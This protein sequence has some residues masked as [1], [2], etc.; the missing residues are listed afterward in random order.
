M[1]IEIPTT[2]PDETTKPLTLLTLLAPNLTR[3]EIFG[4]SEYRLQPDLGPDEVRPLANEPAT[5]IIEA[6]SSINS[7]A[8]LLINPETLVQRGQRE[9]LYCDNGFTLIPI[10]GNDPKNRQITLSII[11]QELY[12]Q[13]VT[14]F[15]F[16]DTNQTNIIRQ[17]TYISP[18][19][20]LAEINNRFHFV[21]PG[22]VPITD[23]VTSKNLIKTPYSSQRIPRINSGPVSG[24]VYDMSF[25]RSDS[26]EPNQEVT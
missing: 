15:V 24:V 22:I 19:S 1:S 5:I 11:T 7:P 9:V 17:I 4:D 13:A 16:P 20:K 23:S 21:R 8:A 26:E 25:K 18:S 14:G 3:L 6:I 12:L 10:T 2:T